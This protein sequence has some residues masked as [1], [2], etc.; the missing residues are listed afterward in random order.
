V[1][2]ATMTWLTV[3]WAV[4]VAGRLAPRSVEVPAGE[5]SERARELKLVGRLD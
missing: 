5:R 4:A 2:L 3:L 1:T